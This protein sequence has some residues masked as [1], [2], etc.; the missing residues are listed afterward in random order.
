[1]KISVFETRAG[2]ARR[3]SVWPTAVSPGPSQP[4]V[5][6]DLLDQLETRLAEQGVR[7]LAMVLREGRGSGL[8]SPGRTS[9][10]SRAC[11]I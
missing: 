11:G 10:T 7:K 8:S 6:H 9:S 1:V 5:A 2:N 3:S 4:E